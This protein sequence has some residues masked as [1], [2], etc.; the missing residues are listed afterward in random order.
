MKKT[1]FI[2]I[3]LSGLMYL[4]F[5]QAKSEDLSIKPEP[6]AEKEFKFPDYK[7]ITLD[8]GLKVFLIEDH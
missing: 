7:E 4:S 5:L 6:M 2:F 1:S 3:L 8:N